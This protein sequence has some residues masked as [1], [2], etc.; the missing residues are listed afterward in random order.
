[1]QDSFRN[2]LCQNNKKQESYN[3]LFQSQGFGLG[4]D[5]LF[6]SEGKRQKI[7]PNG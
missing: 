1:M 3:N 2:I 4:M 6:F 7:D 5:L